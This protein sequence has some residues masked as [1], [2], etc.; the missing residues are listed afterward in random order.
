M[1]TP[2]ISNRSNQIGVG[3]QLHRKDL[4]IIVGRG[5]WDYPEN[6]SGNFH[7]HL[8]NHILSDVYH[9]GAAM[10]EEITGIHLSGLSLGK[11]VAVVCSQCKLNFVIVRRMTF[12]RAEPACSVRFNQRFVKCERCLIAVISNL[13]IGQRLGGQFH[14]SGILDLVT[15]FPLDT[16]SIRKRPGTIVYRH[17][18]LHG[19]VAG[20]RDFI[21]QLLL[22]AGNSERCHSKH[23]D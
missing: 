14:Y 3:R 13:L 8:R 22:V 12:G 10:Q 17:H 7:L 4:L 11:Q 5:I 16:F 23:C 9:P 1:A 6:S 18:H 20:R 2:V 15:D 19:T 21:L